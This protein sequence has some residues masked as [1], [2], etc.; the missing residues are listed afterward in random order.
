MTLV[1]K[2]EPLGRRKDFSMLFQLACVRFGRS[3]FRLVVL[4]VLTLSTPGFYQ[5]VI[6]VLQFGTQGQ[7]EPQCLGVL[8]LA[9]PLSFL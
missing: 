9:R 2:E 6:E 3:S 4:G 7:S 1:R 5:V 8:V